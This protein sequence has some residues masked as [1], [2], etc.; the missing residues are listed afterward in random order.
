MGSN[1]VSWVAHVSVLLALLACGPPEVTAS[2]R[3]KLAKQCEMGV[4]VRDPAEEANALTTLD[5]MHCKRGLTGAQKCPEWRRQIVGICY[6]KDTS[7][8]Y[9][10]VVTTTTRHQTDAREAM[11]DA[12]RLGVSKTASIT[13]YCRDYNQ[14]STRCGR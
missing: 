3:E 6:Q 5:A 8:E 12:M 4:G 10:K 13:V 2:D 1:A 14:C 11:C 7:V 9:F